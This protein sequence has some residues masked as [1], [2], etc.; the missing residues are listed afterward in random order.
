MKNTYFIHSFPSTEN[1]L[2]HTIINPDTK[3]ACY[4]DILIRHNFFEKEI[5]NAKLYEIAEK[6]IKEYGSSRCYF[7]SYKDDDALLELTKI[8]DAVYEEQNISNLNEEIIQNF[9]SDLMLSAT[10]S[11]A[12]KTL[13]I[14]YGDFVG[15]LNELVREC[16]VEYNLPVSTKN[17]GKKIYELIRQ[18]ILS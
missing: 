14:Y 17:E 5:I 6:A 8:I 7:I 15:D 2:Y 11:A 18:R 3:K 1:V 12:F 10:M 9:A 4:P 13:L 16:T